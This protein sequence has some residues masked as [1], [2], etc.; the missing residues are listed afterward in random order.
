MK[1]ENLPNKGNTFRNIRFKEFRE[2]AE[3]E[4]GKLRNKTKQKQKSPKYW[5]LLMERISEQRKRKSKDK[6]NNQI[7]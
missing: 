6:K 2:I 3:D 1:K 7:G 4:V 5:M